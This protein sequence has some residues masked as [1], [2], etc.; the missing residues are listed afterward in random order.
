VRARQ[1]TR[2]LSSSSE[3]PSVEIAGSEWIRAASVAAAR[4][5]PAFATHPPRYTAD[6][7]RRLRCHGDGPVVH[8]YSLD[9]RL[10]LPARGITHITHTT[11]S[12][13]SPPSSCTIAG[14]AS[15]EP[16]HRR[17]RA[18]IGCSRGIHGSES[19]PLAFWLR[20]LLRAALD[21][22]P[23]QLLGCSYAGRASG[24]RWAACTTQSLGSDR[25]SSTLPGQLRH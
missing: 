24:Q 4:R 23:R 1:K 7:R 6:P 16:C 10:G 8:R 15:G 11:S 14:Q 18:P 22:R 9:H 25:R 12:E 19:R 13:N 3:E 17:V 21:L 5:R 2:P 20:D